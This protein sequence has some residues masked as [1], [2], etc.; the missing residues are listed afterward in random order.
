M[1]QVGRNYEIEEY[2][3]AA[4]LSHQAAEDIMDELRCL[5]AA[6]RVVRWVGERSG[7]P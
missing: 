7:L 2:S 6:R 4:F 5:R 1:R 3:V